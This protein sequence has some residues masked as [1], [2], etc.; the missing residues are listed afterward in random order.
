MTTFKSSSPTPP[1]DTEDTEDT[2][3]VNA[4]HKT[5]RHKRYR[6]TEDTKDTHD[7]APV[8]CVTT[9]QDAVEFSLAKRVGKHTLFLF[10]R[11]LKAMEV[12]TRK[13]IQ[14]S[15]LEGM[16]AKWWAVA[17]RKLP[18]GSDFTVFMVEF[19]GAYRKAKVP[20]HM[21]PLE[22]AFLYADA[23]ATDPKFGPVVGR[24]VLACERLQQI[25]GK[26]PFY[27]G[28]RTAA[29]I[30]GTKD[31]YAAMNTIEFLVRREFM[32]CVEKGSGKRASRYQLTPH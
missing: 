11:A 27:I 32:R 26:D 28:V 18:N 31:Y 29:K 16:F 8:A 2:L 14:D 23:N 10:A 3:V 5:L 1:D 20:L 4:K 21:N 13:K 24:L 19:L 17:Q 12:V 22:E 25:A 15:E 9:L 30:L 6:E 7:S